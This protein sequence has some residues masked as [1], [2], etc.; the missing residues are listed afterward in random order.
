MARKTAAFDFPSYIPGRIADVT[1]LLV[2][3]GGGIWQL[4]ARTNGDIRVSNN[5]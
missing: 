3:T 2:P 5:P 4:R 1:G